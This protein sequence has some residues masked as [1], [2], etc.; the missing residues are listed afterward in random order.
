MGATELLRTEAGFCGLGI[1]CF[2][3]SRASSL[4]LARSVYGYSFPE[5]LSGL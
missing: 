1:I 4:E 2:L 5:N 3:G